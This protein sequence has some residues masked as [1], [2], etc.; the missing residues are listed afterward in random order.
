MPSIV[1]NN[2]E[3]PSFTKS[4]SFYRNRFKQ[5]LRTPVYRFVPRNL[6][7]DWSD[8]QMKILSFFKNKLDEDEGE[9]DGISVLLL[10]LSGAAK[11]TVSTQIRYILFQKHKKAA[12]A[13]PTGNVAVENSYVTIHHLLGIQKFQCRKSWYELAVNGEISDAAI[14]NLQELEYLFIDEYSQI[15]PSFL[16][17]ISIAL[18]R[19]K[20]FS[21]PWVGINVVLCGDRIV[22][23][24]RN[25][26][27]G[28]RYDFAREGLDLYRSIK[29]VF[30]LKGSKRH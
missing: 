18:Q 27:E 2:G 15:S 6:E 10:G 7:I 23:F 11:T 12:F 13:T 17:Y 4:V 1:F 14:R 22:S 30:V 8:E 21:K 26:G 5:F 19:A 3:F 16:N 20:Q 25:S 9:E 28:E 24:L 29:K